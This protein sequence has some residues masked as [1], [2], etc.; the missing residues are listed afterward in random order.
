MRV[1]TSPSAIALAGLLCLAVAMG[2]GRFAFTPLLPMMLAEGHVSLTE[3]S[4]M[5]SA[6]YLGYLLGALSAGRLPMRAPL[7]LGLG[8]L[9]VIATT[10]LMALPLTPPTW[11]VWRLLAGMA[12]AWVLI[13]TSSLCLARLDNTRAGTAFAGVGCGIAVTGIICLVLAVLDVSSAW[14]WIF[15]AAISLA[16]ATGAW[17]LLTAGIQEKGTAAMPK[18]TAMPAQDQPTQRLLSLCY[19]LYG[20]GYILPATYLPAQAHALVSDPAL[21]GLAWPVFGIAAAVSTLL[22]AG[23]RLRT[24]PRRTLW[25]VSQVVMTIGVLLPLLWPTL[26]A[27]IVA[28]IGVGG[29][30]MVLTMVGM[31]Q[32]ARAVAGASAQRLMAAMTAAFAAGQ[33]AGPLVVSLLGLWTNRSLPLSMGLAAAAL[34]LSTGLLLYAPS[35]PQSSSETSHDRE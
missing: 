34:I 3:G 8:L 19:G 2:V 25:A 33:L 12:S 24:V 6:N 11:M 29:T 9:V 35:S 10:A 22:V 4:W 31:M 16:A 14:S 7:L 1:Q 32:E 23:R 15:L 30:F 28:A 26:A 27:I 18:A 5:A 21:F 17:P 20:F 13:T